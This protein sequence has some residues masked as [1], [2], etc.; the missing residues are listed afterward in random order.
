MAWS[1]SRTNM[2]DALWIYKVAPQS[3]SPVVLSNIMEMGA[4]TPRDKRPTKN[5][6]FKDKDAL[7]F[8][9]QAGT[10][11]LE[12]FPAQGFINYF[13]DAA[14]AGM[15]EAVTGVPSEDEALRLALACLPRF[16]IDRSQLAEKSCSELRIY[17]TMRKRGGFNKAQGNPV[18]EIDLRGVSFVRRIDN[19]EFTGFGNAGGFFVSFGNHGKIRE[20]QVVWRNLQPFKLVEMP[21]GD[22]F[23]RWIREGKSVIT[24]T[25]PPAVDWKQVQELNVIKLKPYY[26]GE[27]GDRVQTYAIPS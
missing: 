2:P 12:I 3:F 5:A 8:Q 22:T 15:K 10:R 14:L 27:G 21:S 24:E 20:L 23:I 4:V 25:Q 26:L 18:E 7:F 16:G 11:R 6:P 19:I 1:A 9:N 13:D 17:R